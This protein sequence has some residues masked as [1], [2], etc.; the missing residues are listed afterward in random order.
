MESAI[1]LLKEISIGSLIPGTFFAF[2]SVANKNVHPR[3]R[4]RLA[5]FLLKGHINDDS[6]NFAN[7]FIDLLNGDYIPKSQIGARHDIARQPHAFG[8]LGVVAVAQT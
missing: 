4:K 2:F 6:S 8:D 7:S 1:S 5:S 3:L